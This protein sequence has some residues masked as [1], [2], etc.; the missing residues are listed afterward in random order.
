M[1]AAQLYLIAEV[2][3]GPAAVDRLRAALRAAPVASVLLIPVPGEPLAASTLKPLVDAIQAE[4]VAALIYADPA[5][6]RAVRADGVHLSACDNVEAAFATAR[7]ILGTRYIIGSDAGASRH[8][9]MTLGELGADYVAFDSAVGRET[10]T[11]LLVWW[12]EI[13]EVPC[14]GFD[15]LTPTEAAEM[16]DAGA[17]FVAVRLPGTAT[18]ADTQ[19][20]VRAAAQSMAPRQPSPDA[21]VLPAS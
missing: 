4:N 18:P 5:L 12:S 20:F 16:A 3:P 19:A 6:A 2:R 11:G 13:F 10:Q 7:D 21:D 15:A 1:A 8:D 9:A 17:D 14:V